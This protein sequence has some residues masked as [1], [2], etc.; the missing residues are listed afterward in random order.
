[1]THV[2]YADEMSDKR[3]PADQNKLA[4]LFNSIDT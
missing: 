3:P 2:Y 4:A 1:M